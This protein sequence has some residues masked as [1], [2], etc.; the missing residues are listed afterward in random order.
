MGLIEVD[1]PEELAREALK[2]THTQDE[3]ERY[4]MDS[5]DDIKLNW[6]DSVVSGSKSPVRTT[7]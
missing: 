7:K 2:N 4:V 6:P 3:A 5:V 1:I